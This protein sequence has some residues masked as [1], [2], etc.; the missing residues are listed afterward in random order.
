VVIPSGNLGNAA[1][2]FAGFRMAKELGLTDRMPRLCV[3]QAAR[4]NPMYR[5]FIA[6]SDEVAPVVA[7]PT[8]ASAIGSATPSALR[9]RWRRF[10]G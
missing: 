6:H 2:L 8:Q 4:A 1:A 7:E 3:A 9:A 5:A 10:A